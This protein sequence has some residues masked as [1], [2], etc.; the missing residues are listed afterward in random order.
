MKQ[1]A[2]K[3]LDEILEQRKTASPDESYTAKLFS[4]GQDSILK[5]VGEEATETVIASKSGDK[6]EI[7]HEIADLWFHTMVLLKFHDLD[8][9]DIL[10]EL[11]SRFGLS[12]LE[13]KANRKK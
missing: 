11:E 7:I 6:A 3:L 8:S 1:N 4:D 9:D 12:G 13:E 5:K 2:L 10:K